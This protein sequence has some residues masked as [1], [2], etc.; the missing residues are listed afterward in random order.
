MAGRREELDSKEDLLL[1]RSRQGYKGYKRGLVSQ[2][3]TQMEESLL[4]CCV[5]N[6]ISYDACNYGNGQGMCCESC[7]VVGEVAQGIGAIRTMV[8]N[9]RCQCPLSL[10]GCEWEGTIQGVWGHLDACAS[11]VV[12]CPYGK[13]GCDVSLKRGQLETHRRG[14]KEYHTELVMVRLGNQVEEQ[15]GTIQRLEKLVEEMREYYKKN[16]VIWKITQVKEIKAA[17]KQPQQQQQQYQQPQQGNPFQ[18]HRE[19]VPVPPFTSGYSFPTSTT[20]SHMFN[21]PNLSTSARNS[22]M[23]PNQFIGPS[24]QL[25]S[26]SL[27]LQLEVKQTGYLTLSLCNLTQ[28]NTNAIEPQFQM[29]SMSGLP[30]GLQPTTPRVQLQQE[31]CSQVKFKLTLF[32]KIN[33]DDNWIQ[34]IGPLKLDSTTQSLPLADLESVTLLSEEFSYDDTILLQLLYS[35]S[36]T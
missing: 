31:P 3:L 1:V 28:L 16:E 7:L 11:L 26:Y 34:E 22:N 10:K 14:S 9:L 24:F 6:G 4:V 5:C 27:R 18:Q 19:Y 12:A 32:N 2:Q 13:Y 15:F 25:D 35:V 33:T 17:I 20:S 23:N 8:S 36:N 21:Q 30:M 29:M